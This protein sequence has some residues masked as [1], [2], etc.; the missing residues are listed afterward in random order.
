MLFRTIRR[1]LAVAAATCALVPH[2][3]AQAV[4]GFGEDATVAPHGTLR[5]RVS[6]E[7]TRFDRTL[8]GTADTL[9]RTE[10]RIRVATL[11]LELGL[12][13]RLAIGAN[14]PVVATKAI[15]TA[16]SLHGDL[17]RVADSVMT[18]DHN[19]FGDVEVYGKLV[20]L[21]TLSERQRTAPPPGFHIRSALTGMV[22]LGT[23]RHID[24]TDF[25]G[26]SVGDGQT[27]LEARS[28][29]D[30]LFGRHVWTSIIA[31]Y[32]HQLAD[33]LPV[34]VT[35]AGAPFS[36][37]Y[38]PFEADRKLGDYF[39]IEA[40][41]RVS[42]GRYFSVAA[43]YRYRHKRADRYTGTQQVA[44]NDVPVTLDASVLDTGTT[45][46]EHRVGFGATYSSV[47]SYVTGQAQFPVEITYEHSNV[48]HVSGGLP[49]RSRD[50]ISLRWYVRLFGGDFTR[51]AARNPR[52][53]K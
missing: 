47:A 45:L 41:P 52:R 23:G 5:A 19:G 14:V 36:T 10:S 35:P 1:A 20:W 50:Q 33:R 2:A 29:T 39:E 51:G 37:V 42:L 30:L 17:G 53:R 27:D 7:W 32:T 16:S 12:L 24:P 43:Q 44:V 3:R 48:V 46:A 13:N 22:R 25:F 38:P 26:I 40:T 4:I 11:S 18:S 15:T 28:Q 49:K 8:Q 21:R 34:V 6:N 31:R 9:F